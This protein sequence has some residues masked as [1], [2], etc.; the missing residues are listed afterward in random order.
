MKCKAPDHISWYSSLQIHMVGL[1]FESQLLIAPV[2]AHQ[3]V[4]GE[5]YGVATK[6]MGDV[7]SA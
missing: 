6:F 2:C 5:I 4:V 1:E 7:V 3:V